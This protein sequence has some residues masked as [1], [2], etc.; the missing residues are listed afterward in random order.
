MN[1]MAG[2]QNGA[3][4]RP[5]GVQVLGA[6]PPLLVGAYVG[7]SVLAGR[8]SSAPGSGADP[9]AGAGA[10][11]G[12]G[13]V[14]ALMLGCVLVAGS[15]IAVRR[16]LPEWGYTWLGACGAL[17]AVLAR[18]WVSEQLDV[19]AGHFPIGT[20]LVS[21]AVIAISTATVAAARAGPRQAGLAGMGLASAFALATMGSLALPPFREAGLALAAMPLACIMATLIYLYL[22]L[23]LPREGG[24]SAAPLLGMFSANAVVAT[25]AGRAWQPWLSAQGKPPAFWGFLLILTCFLMAPLALRFFIRAAARYLRP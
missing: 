22:D 21:V 6:L 7:F 23:C 9:T 10:G 19:L 4:V 15:V 14:A 8:P 24:A 5:T 20:V 12:A 16:H 13:F 17:L 18:I 25:I 3:A 1:S 11:L 2:S